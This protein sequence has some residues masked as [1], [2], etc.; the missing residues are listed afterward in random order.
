M[1]AYMRTSL[2]TCTSCHV[3]AWFLYRCIPLRP[4]YLCVDSLAPACPTSGANV[5][6]CLVRPQ[7]CYRTRL[8]C[9]LCCCYVPG[10]LPKS[11]Y[12]YIYIHTCSYS[13]DSIRCM[14]TGTCTVEDSRAARTR[15]ISAYDVVE[16]ANERR[17]AT[18]NNE[19]FTYHLPVQ[20]VSFYMRVKLLAR[21]DRCPLHLNCQAL[22]R[23]RQRHQHDPTHAHRQNVGC[24][25]RAPVVLG[26]VLGAVAVE[27]V[28]IRPFHISQRANGMLSRQRCLLC[29]LLL[30]RDF[31]SCVARHGCDLA[32]TRVA[33]AVSCSL[34]FGGVAPLLIHRQ[35]VT[36][37]PNLAPILEYKNTSAVR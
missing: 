29:G 11:Y 20:I 27:H 5:R 14:D 25:R 3:S 18:R 35:A 1:L 31:I 34:G 13:Y 33:L 19:H 9:I 17:K 16:V 12:I 15:M 8:R 28:F 24:A 30:G 32:S 26:Y 36:V 21:L 10:I 7:T 2:C 23:G 6:V 22:Q 37:S 4:T